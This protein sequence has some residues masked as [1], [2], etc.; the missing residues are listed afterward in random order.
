LIFN[1]M[2]VARR[3][4]SATSH[5]CENSKLERSG[6]FPE[7]AEAQRRVCSR[8]LMRISQQRLSRVAR[9]MSM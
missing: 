9:P 5:W 7:V 6:W 1:V 3:L 4:V 8:W 2:A